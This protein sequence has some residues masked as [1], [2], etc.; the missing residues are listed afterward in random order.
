LA[1]AK[2]SCF[3]R[4]HPRMACNLFIRLA[5]VFLFLLAPLCSRLGQD[6]PTFA[7]SA[8]STPRPTSEPLRRRK[9]S[10]RPPSQEPDH[11]LLELRGLSLDGRGVVED[12]PDLA[13]A[14]L[15]R[16]KA[17]GKAPTE[18]HFMAALAVMED[19]RRHE[20]AVQLVAD[21]RKAGMRPETPAY[22]SAIRAC[23]GVDPDQA[24]SLLREA[25]PE[26]TMPTMPPY[27]AA[28]EALVKADRLEEADDLYAEMQ[29]FGGLLQLWTE[30]YLLDLQDLPNEVAIT[31][32]RAA[33]EQFAA[34]VAKGK[35]GKGRLT[36]L[37]GPSTKVGATKQRAVKA[38]LRDHY[39]FK[40]RADP[41]KIGRLYVPFTELQDY[42]QK[43]LA[44]WRSNVVDL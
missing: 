38:V 4:A 16:M 23:I 1:R 41:P 43:Q 6:G 40:V 25:V 44:A 39:G 21:M 35:A 3:G 8:R 36:I 42:G 7:R 28:I 22:A 27:F 2:A 9:W 34:N 32:T 17:A 29:R 15:D 12:A 20:E 11:Y 30:S 24:V 10:Q 14:V 37:T 19:N 31:A 5:A 13:V 18:L 33:V 26:G